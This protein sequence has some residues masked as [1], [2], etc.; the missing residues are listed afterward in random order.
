MVNSGKRPDLV[1]F[2]DLY[3]KLTDVRTVAGADSRY[4]STAASVPGHGAVWG[5]AQKNEAWLEL[6][7]RQGDTFIPLCH[8]AGGRL[9][10]QAL[11]FLDE[12]SSAAGGSQSDRVAFKTYALQRL[13]AATFRGVAMLI[14]SRPVLRTGP[15]VPSER[16]EL[17]LPPPPLRAVINFS[18]HLCFPHTD[19]ATANTTTAAPRTTPAF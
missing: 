13:H 19:F 7:Q 15:E 1:V 5:A 3:N 16:G 14:N 2:M 18:S 6:A 4:C 11:D 17:P 8:E 9:G 10:A 12:L